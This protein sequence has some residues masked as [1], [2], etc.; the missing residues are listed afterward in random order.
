MKRLNSNY[1]LKLKKKLMK[2]LIK[3]LRIFQEI[4]SQYSSL[5]KE[6]L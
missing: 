6:M 5:V 2:T 3:F 4:I 1:I